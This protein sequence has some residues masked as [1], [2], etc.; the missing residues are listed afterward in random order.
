MYKK[1]HIP[2]NR[3]V[4]WDKDFRKGFVVAYNYCFG[5]EIK[6]GAFTGTPASATFSFT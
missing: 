6:L 4:A 5:A 1:S 2:T 3:N